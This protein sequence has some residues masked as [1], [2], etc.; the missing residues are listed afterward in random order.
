MAALPSLLGCSPRAPAMSSWHP[1]T[2]HGECCFQNHAQ[3]CQFLLFCS[4]CPRS[5]SLSQR[6]CIYSCG[7]VDGILDLHC[8]SLA[9][10]TG[11][12]WMSSQPWRVLQRPL[13]LLAEK[14]RASRECG[15]S[16]QVAHGASPKLP[17]GCQWTHC[18]L[19][20]MFQGWAL[21]VTANALCSP[22]PC[23]CVWGGGGGGG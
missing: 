6:C 11:C 10:I 17:M 3:P 13:L 18:A 9:P 19:P 15:S 12:K 23:V 14:W 2:Q 22:H 4:W 21:Q 5:F 7:L 8:P 1:S 20:A 16:V